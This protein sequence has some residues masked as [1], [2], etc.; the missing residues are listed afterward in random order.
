MSEVSTLDTSIIKAPAWCEVRLGAIQSNLRKIQNWIGPSVGVMGV[1]KANAYGH[2]MI[3]VAR[4]LQQEVDYLAVASLVEAQILRQNKITAP[5]L[6]M[7]VTPSQEVELAAQLK[8]ALTLSDWAMALEM[9]ERLTKSGQV[10]TVHLKVDSGMGRM[11]LWPEQ[12]FALIQRLAASQQFFLEGVF[13]HFSSAD[14]DNRSITLDQISKFSTLIARCKQESMTFKWVHAANSA[15]LLRYAPAHFN[16]V[17]PGLALYGVIPCPFGSFRLEQAMSLKT[18]IALVKNFPPGQAVSYGATYVTP[19]ETRLA[20][21]PVGY[22]SGYPWSL[23]SKAQVIMNGQ[24]FSVVGRICM[25]SMMVDLQNS[26]FPVGQEVILIGG[27]PERQISILD[28]AQKAST[29]PYEI[30]TRLSAQ[31]PRVFLT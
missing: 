1:V 26:R 22:S 6:V 23:S 25:D 24:L 14:L 10:L 31:L 21:L 29:I 13:T 7:G 27:T 9:E 30:L 15:G 28:L 5:I 4:A 20:V 19:R 8:V 2:G 17:R 11:G 18:R 12:A 16:M 3:E